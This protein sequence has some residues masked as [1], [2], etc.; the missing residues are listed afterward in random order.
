MAVRLARCPKATSVYLSFYTV[1]ASGTVF[2][3]TALQT[4]ASS[5]SVIVQAISALPKQGCGGDKTS[6]QKNSDKNRV[7]EDASLPPLQQGWFRLGDT[8]WKYP[9]GRVGQ[10][11]RPDGSA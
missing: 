1:A 5:A 2:G 3:K 7:T 4:V 8:F 9:D 10:H 11:K 6:Y